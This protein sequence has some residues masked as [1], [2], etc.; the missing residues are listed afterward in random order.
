MSDLPHLRLEGEPSS[1]PYT[2]A[3]PAPQG[4]TFNLPARNQPAHAKDVRSALETAD[5]EAK[6]RLEEDEAAHPELLEWKPKGLVLTFESE[7]NHPLS[8]EGLE[9]HG[10][11]HLL[12]L[13]ERGGLQTARVFVPEK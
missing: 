5:A 12:G 1:S 2:Y 10:G 4:V 3:G 9:R 7:P 11:I 13:T 8:L 6:R